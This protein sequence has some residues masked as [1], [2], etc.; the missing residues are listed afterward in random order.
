MY[1]FVFFAFLFDITL[2]LQP[3]QVYQYVK[4]PSL[5][6]QNK[7]FGNEN[8]ANDHTQQFD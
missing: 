4:S 1:L 5:F 7:L 8:K 6:I 3:Q 2:L